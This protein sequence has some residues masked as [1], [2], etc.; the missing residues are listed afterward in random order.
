MIGKVGRG[1]KIGGLLVY[2]LGEGEH[3]EHENRHVIAGSPTVMREA[4]LA[5]FDGPGDKK[6]SRDVALAIAHE[7]DI[8]RRL[9][10]TQ[11]RMRAKPVAAGARGPRSDVVERAAK[12]EPSEMRDAPVWHCILSLEVGETLDDETWSKLVGEF[13]DEMGF[14]ASSDA[15]RA[16]A[17][18]AAVGHGPSG[19]RDSPERKEHVHIAASLVREDGSKVSTYD[20]GPGKAKGDWPRVQEVVNLLEHRYGLRVLA[21][22]EQGGALSGNSRAEIERAK[23]DQAPETERERLR[24]MVRAA[25]VSADSETAFVRELRD[26][27]ISVV[28]RWAA[29]GKTAV[30]GY[31]VRLRHGNT[32]AGPWLGGGTLAK[33]LNLTAL[34]EQQW[35]DSPQS[36]AAAVAAWATPKTTTGTGERVARG[37]DDA[38]LWQQASRQFG[39]WHER[40]G[41]IP[42]TDRARWAWV[43]GQAAGVFAAWSERLEGEQPGAFA[44]AAAELTRSAQL[45]KGEAHYRPTSAE[46]HIGEIAQVLLSAGST[47]S[48]SSRPGQGDVTTAV[49]A[50]VLAA[51][52]L[53]LIA[54]IAIA[55]EI[56]RAHRTRGELAR[57]VVVQGVV[58]TN[59]EPLRQ[60]WVPQVSEWREREAAVNLAAEPHIEPRRERATAPQSK[61]WESSKAAAAARGPLT[62]PSKTTRKKRVL[63]TEMTV[64]QRQLERGSLSWKAGSARFDVKPKMWGDEDLVAELDERRTEIELLK[65]DLQRRRVE[66][67]RVRQAKIDN[68]ELVR[69]AG[70]IE[71]AMEVEQD[72]DAVV[73]EER[74]LRARRVQLRDQL[75][76]TPRHKMIARQKLTTEIGKAEEQLREIAPET[77]AA[78]AAANVAAE[79]TGTPRHAWDETIREADPRRQKARLG[80]AEELDRREFA[81]DR[82][83]LA[84]LERDFDKFDSERTRRGTLTAAQRVAEQQARARGQEPGK[85]PTK[86]PE[87][88]GTPAPDYN[89][90]ITPPTYGKKRDN[91]LGL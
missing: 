88:P 71:P 81:E 57:A 27:G 18:W 83:Y 32:E 90:G 30:V 50:A 72:A 8:P 1:Q 7:I 78:R 14:S 87:K 41:Q 67:D 73:R 89:P 19:K 46:K 91:G 21:S 12:G 34:R 26:A 52:L 76:N 49:A 84:H 23:R 74:Q 37:L 9:Y 33:D 25:A 69:R 48:E 4:W 15:K 64:E 68:T 40:L 53:L 42:H 24:R 82:A 44:A 36:R 39:Q 60:T 43:A 38:E 3:N 58:D 63:Y 28:P 86:G 51:M 55:L 62:P 31:K 29:G 59:L 45:P 54:A 35:D 56:V 77:A 11:S 13:M 16:Q 85:K 10:G 70:L 66:G 47:R 2:L 17:R 65:A 5:T 6:A 61:P 75:D 80:T 79:S 20:Y 22:R